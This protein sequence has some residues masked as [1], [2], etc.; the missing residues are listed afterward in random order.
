MEVI[1]HDDEAE[2]G[3][4]VTMAGSFKELQEGG[5]IPIGTHDILAGVAPAGHVIVSIWELNT[6]GS[7]H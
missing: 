7:G 6:Q 3:N 4:F 5:T 2:Y 1:P